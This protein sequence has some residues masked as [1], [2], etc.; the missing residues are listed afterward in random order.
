MSGDLL[1][2]ARRLGVVVVQNPTHFAFEPGMLER[3]FGGRPAGFQA[4]R[5][6][7][8]AGVPLAFGSDGPFNPFLNL[9]FATTH[10]NNPTEAL[11]RE[12]AVRAFTKG[13]AYA[14]F[15]ERDKGTLGVGMLADLAVLSQD[16][17]TVRAQA[18]PATT[19]VL[20]IV[21]GRIIHDDLTRNRAPIGQC[22]THRD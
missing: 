19:S 10:P 4:V 22:A 13:S 2:I 18:L 6:L 16:I 8:D 12:Q 21:G 9:M 7:V 20:T 15:A 17:F 11:T 3:R 1:P 14:E 5:S